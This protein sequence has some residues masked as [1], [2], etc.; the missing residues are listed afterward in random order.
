LER[1]LALFQPGRDD[2]LAF[3]FAADSGVSS[4]AYLAIASWPLGEVDR[5]VSLIDRSMRG[6]HAY[7]ILARA[8][9][10]QRRP[11]CSN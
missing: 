2:D 7:H 9:G 5:S 3:R 8:A 1:A 10:E 4:M 11:L 6:W